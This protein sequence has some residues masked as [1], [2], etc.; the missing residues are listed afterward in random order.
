MRRA[1]LFTVL[2]V[3]FV[4]ATGAY[5]EEK[6]WGD[7]AELSFVDTGGNTDITTLSAKNLLQYKFSEKLQGAW[8]VGALYGKTDGEKSAESYFSDLRLDY[9]FTNRFY[10]FAAAGWSQDEF[11]GI[12]SRYYVGPGVGYKFI[13]GPKHF[14][15][16]EVGANYVYENYTD[17]TYEAYIEGRAYARYEYAFTEKNKFSQSVE[18]LYDFEDGDNYTVNSETALISALSDYL[19][20]KTSYV[21]KYD[22]QPVPSTLKET[23]TIL[24]VTLVVNF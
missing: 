15:L 13:T 14:L 2:P 23:D 7:Q 16:G 1:I 20:L 9:L 18:Y 8:T 10:S 22:N 17:D 5:A 21:V 11:A 6:R 12:D 3:I 4:L 19:S 24:S